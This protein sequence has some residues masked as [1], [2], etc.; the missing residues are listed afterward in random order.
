MRH[1]ALLVLPLVG[2]NLPLSEA[3]SI[4]RAGGGAVA[5]EGPIRSEDY[6][7]TYFETP[8]SDTVKY[9]GGNLG[10]TNWKDLP[11]P[12]NQCGGGGQANGFGQS[13]IVIPYEKT[14]KGCDSHMNR[15]ETAPGDCTWQD[16]DFPIMKDAVIVRAKVDKYH[17]DKPICS[18]G[19][20]F[21]PDNDN[22]LYDIQELRMKTG[23]DHIVEG[24][25]FV[26]EFEVI[27]TERDGNTQAAFSI[28]VIPDYVKSSNTTND[29]S[30]ME[31]GWRNSF[32]ETYDFCYE[33]PE[34]SGIFNVNTALKKQQKF[35]MCEAFDDREKAQLNLPP[36]EETS[37][38]V[39]P[40]FAEIIIEEARKQ[41]G[42]AAYKGSLTRPPCTENVYWNV[43][44]SP[45]TLQLDQFFHI[46]QLINCFQ[47]K[48]TC[49]FASAA[50]EFGLTARPSQQ[51]NGREIIL[52]CANG[53]DIDME[54]KGEV[55]TKVKYY[56]PKPIKP[57]HALLFPFFV[58]ACSLVIFYVLTRYLHFIP[59]TAVLFL[60]GTVMGA[61]IANEEAKGGQLL[62][63]TR[64]YDNIHGNLLLLVF[65]P[66]LLFKVR[67][68]SCLIFLPFLD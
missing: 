19:S 51:I 67:Y 52:R 23:A 26:M 56:P 47:E 42:I 28:P 34:G 60:L 31:N 66:G 62:K 58:M 36:G 41:L 61:I 68:D 11:I 63:S 50:S 53:P 30:E 25:T 22:H 45:I 13:P 43:A 21:L 57:Y 37:S 33:N 20:L 44:L 24:Y 39:V 64:M 12:N 1:V 9:N 54:L 16:V 46:A 49:E 29:F 38:N 48:S 40:N 5:V 32:W 10:P 17:S 59:Y 55:Q 3:Q 4:L 65:L 6:L 27:A 14:T 18:L 2:L 8:L 35:I 7:W 15:Y